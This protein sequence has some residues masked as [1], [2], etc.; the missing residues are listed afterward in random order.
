VSNG[1]RAIDEEKEE[2]L[3]RIYRMA[4]N[5][6]LSVGLNRADADA[7]GNQVAAQAFARWDQFIDEGEGSRARWAWCIARNV[8][9]SRRRHEITAGECEAELSR[10]EEQ[11]RATASPEEVLLNAEATKER[12]ELFGSLEPSLGAAVSIVARQASQ[13]MSRT[14]AAKLLGVNIHKYDRFAR[15]VKRELKC[16]VDNRFTDP[17]ELFG[18]GER[19]DP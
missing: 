16:A 13:I 2:W 7:V 9:A 11:Q 17:S 1:N 6:A 5:K 15:Y 3:K 14:E 8:L 19:S 18:D 4:R 12:K 10:Y